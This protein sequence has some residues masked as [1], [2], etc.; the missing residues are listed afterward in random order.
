[1]ANLLG[2]DATIEDMERVYMDNA[3]P[4]E[5]INQVDKFIRAATLLRNATPEESDQAGTRLRMR[6]IQEDI[7]EAKRWRSVYLNSSRRTRQASFTGRC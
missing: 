6:D 3:A 2:S 4:F 1:M 7:N 5:S